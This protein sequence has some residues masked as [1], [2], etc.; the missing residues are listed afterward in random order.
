MKTR[1]APIHLMPS[2]TPGRLTQCGRKAARVQR[3]TLD[4]HDV[5]CRECIAAMRLD[6]RP[7]PACLA[8]RFRF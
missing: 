8:A 6:D 4:K 7:G 3:A 5:T 1:T 2:V